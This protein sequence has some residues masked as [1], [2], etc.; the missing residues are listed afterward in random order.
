MKSKRDFKWNYKTIRGSLS[1][2]YKTENVHSFNTW[3]MHPKSQPS[4][5]EY[6]SV[7]KRGIPRQIS[8]PVREQTLTAKRPNRNTTGSLFCK[9]LPPLEGWHKL[10]KLEM[11]E[12]EIK[13][14]EI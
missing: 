9:S 3:H 7:F 13:F 14:T 10:K 2:G 11:V 1:C 12:R 5:K 8:S 4:M 6:H